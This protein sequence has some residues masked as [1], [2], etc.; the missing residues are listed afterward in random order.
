MSRSAFAVRIY[1]DRQAILLAILGD[2]DS[3]QISLRVGSKMELF[4]TALLGEKS[5]LTKH[6]ALYR[7]LT[8]QLWEAADQSTLL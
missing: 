2:V 3:R 5:R 4:A 7:K 1:F 8:R 6:A